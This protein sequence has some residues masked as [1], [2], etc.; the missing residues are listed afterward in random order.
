MAGPAA[1]ETLDRPSEAFDWKFAADC[2]VLEAASFAASV[3][4][5]VVDWNRWAGRPASLVDC[6]TTAR[7]TDND[8]VVSMRT[9]RRKGNARDARGVVA[10]RQ[11]ISKGEVVRRWIQFS[12]ATGKFRERRANDRQ[13][14]A[15]N[16]AKLQLLVNR[17]YKNISCP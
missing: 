16:S 9:R 15:A 2:D 1:E 13:G 7:D 14:I 17:R 3:A 4:F 6:R 5:A 12:P 10:G 8:I 11:L